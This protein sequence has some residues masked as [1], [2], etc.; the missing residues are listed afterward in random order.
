MCN[1]YEIRSTIRRSSDRPTLRRI[2]V[3]RIALEHNQLTHRHSSL[4]TTPLVCACCSFLSYCYSAIRSDPFAASLTVTDTEAHA[5]PE[6]RNTQQ[7]HTHTRTHPS[8]LIMFDAPTIL[9]L[10]LW[11]SLVF[12]IG[13]LA[14]YTY[15]TRHVPSIEDSS[16]HTLT[17]TH[18]IKSTSLNTPFI[19]API[20]GSKPAKTP[21]HHSLAQRVLTANQV[22]LVGLF[23]LALWLDEWSRY[24]SSRS[25]TTYGL[26]S[27]TTNHFSMQGDIL[28]KTYYACAFDGSAH[29]IDCFKM[30]GVAGSMFVFGMLALTIAASFATLL[31]R[32]NFHTSARSTSSSLWK[33]ALWQS[34]LLFTLVVSWSLVVEGGSAG[35]EFLSTSFFLALLAFKLSIVQALGV[36]TFI[37]GIIITSESTIPTLQK[38]IVVTPIALQTN[39]H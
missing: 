29:D 4:S 26:L 32:V 36:R 34:L 25:T 24:E 23:S 28:S 37:E 10:S 6:Q 9:I 15:L 39:T 8:S 17:T 31:I 2:N 5:R 27:E 13:A 3:F 22:L 38:V 14:G 20:I 11:L 16:S 35:I 12:L 1:S 21:Q 33:Y 7:Q 30:K 18:A 19:F